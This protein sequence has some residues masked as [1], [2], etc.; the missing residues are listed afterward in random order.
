MIVVEGV[1]GEIGISEGRG[2][3]CAD[4]SEVGATGALAAFDYVTGNTHIVGGGVPRDGDGR[5]GGRGGGERGGR[6]GRGGVGGGVRVAVSE[7]V[8]DVVGER[9]VRTEASSDASVCLLYTS[10]CV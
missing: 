3:W 10:R 4:L 2:C 9:R 8:H 6:C 5:L 1:W 7:V